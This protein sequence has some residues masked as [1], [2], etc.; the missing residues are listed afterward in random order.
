MTNQTTAEEAVELFVVVIVC[1]VIVC[2]FSGVCHMIYVAYF[3]RCCGQHSSEDNSEGIQT[4]SP[5]TEED[6]E[7][8]EINAC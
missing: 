7:M 6:Q 1:T 5:V 4:M 3:R 2:L 8:F